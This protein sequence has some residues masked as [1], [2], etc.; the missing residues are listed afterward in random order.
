VKILYIYFTEDYKVYPESVDTVDDAEA[1]FEVVVT[2]G[3][4][5]NV[6]A[7][8]CSTTSSVNAGA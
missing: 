8:V 2:P 1:V 6:S 3:I 5:W 7:V 4:T